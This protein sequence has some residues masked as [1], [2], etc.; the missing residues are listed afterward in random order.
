MKLLYLAL[1][2]GLPVWAQVGIGTT[3]PTASLD[4]D[5]NVRIRLVEEENNKEVAKD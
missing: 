1:L 3:S 5:G 2:C 4:I